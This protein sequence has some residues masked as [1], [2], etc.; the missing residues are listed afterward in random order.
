MY[1]LQFY[2]LMCAVFTTFYRVLMFDGRK[3]AEKIHISQI[4][5]GICTSY[6]NNNYIFTVLQEITLFHLSFHFLLFCIYFYYDSV[7][8]I[9]SHYPDA[10]EKII[11][12]ISYDN[13]TLYFSIFTTKKNRVD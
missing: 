5:Y 3:R 11:L 2:L 7:I 9:D 6:M 12:F 8:S 13:N 4:E 10:L 1:L